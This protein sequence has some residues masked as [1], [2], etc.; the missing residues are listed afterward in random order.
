MQNK[1]K[2]DF[3]KSKKINK[4]VKKTLKQ[5]KLNILH[6]SSKEKVN[7]NNISKI[8]LKNRNIKQEDE[9]NFFNPDFKNLLDP[10]LMPDMKKAVDRILEA[11]EKGERVVVF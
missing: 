4:T 9:F 1:T 2:D 10:Y 5:N 6:D 7:L 3:K 8:L 11:K